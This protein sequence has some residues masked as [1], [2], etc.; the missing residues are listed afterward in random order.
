[1]KLLFD[2]NLSPRLPALLADC[3]PE[4][5]HDSELRMDR[6]DDRLIWEYARENRF[7]I[8]S[9]DSDF[10][11]IVA[12]RGAPPKV[13]SLQFGNCTTQ[14]VEFS[15]RAVSSQIEEFFRSDTASCLFLKRNQWSVT[16]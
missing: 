11:E 9:R 7:A 1:M 4:A 15:L 10:V 2:E 8:V 6:S 12:V 13:L 5:A 14:Y 3:F 16:K